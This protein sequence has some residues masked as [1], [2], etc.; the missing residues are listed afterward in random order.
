[1]L[2]MVFRSFWTNQQPFMGLTCSERDMLFSIIDSISD[3]VGS[4]GCTEHSYI[5][6]LFVPMCWKS[7]KWFSYRNFRAIT[8]QVFY[9]FC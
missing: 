8:T 7:C 2:L 1:M 3:F 4:V 6:G 5:E 9:S